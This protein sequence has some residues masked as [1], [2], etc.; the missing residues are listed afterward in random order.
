MYNNQGYLSA[1]ELDNITVKKCT[2]I[3]GQDPANNIIQELMQHFTIA[4]K[5]LG[6]YLL[7]CFDGEFTAL[8]EAA[9]KGVTNGEMMDVM[10]DAFGWTVAE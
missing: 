6:R 2:R 10:R 3:F 9:R 1:E 7:D 5:D 8:V 4:L